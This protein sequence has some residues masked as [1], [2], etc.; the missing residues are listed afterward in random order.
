MQ[1]L[2]DRD[3]VIAIGLTVGIDGFVCRLDDSPL[4]VAAALVALEM[5]RDFAMPGFVAGR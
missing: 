3:T 1:R 5:L 4:I 2:V